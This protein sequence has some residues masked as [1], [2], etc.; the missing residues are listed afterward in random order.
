[1]GNKLTTE[2]LGLLMGY[3]VSKILNRSK[4]IINVPVRIATRPLKAGHSNITL[5]ITL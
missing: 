4:Q 3:F 5:L 2:L 1:M